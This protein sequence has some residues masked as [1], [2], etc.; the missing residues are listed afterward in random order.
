MSP[1]A[2]VNVTGT[3]T[4]SGGQVGGV[5]VS[6]DGGT[7]W[8]PATGRASWSYSFRAGASGSLT[9]RS[10]AVD[11]TANRETPSAGVTVTI[12]SGNQS[13]PC[14]IWGTAATPARAAETSDTGPL[15]VG[16]KFRSSA[17]GRIT[18]VRF[19]KGATN[20]GTHV[21][22]L[23]TGTGTLLATA[24]FTNETATGWQEVAFSS[25]VTITAGTT[26]V[27]SYYA[28]R[29]NYAVNED[30]FANGGGVDSPPLR[31][32]SD[33][34]DGGN[35]VYGY[36]ALGTFP[37]GTYRSENYWVDVL[38]EPSGADTTA[39]TVTGV[40][41]ASGATGV[42]ASANAT[43]TFSEAMSAASI[44]TANF[45]LRGPGGAL[46]PGAVSYDAASRTATLNPTAA[47]AASTAYTATVKGGASGVKDLA[48]NA[49]ATDRTWTFTT[50]ASGGGGLGCPCSIWGTSA[51]PQRAAETGDTGPLEVGVKFRSQ[52]DGKITALRFYK[53]ATNTG[54]HVGHLWTRT[55]TLLASA[56]F[57]NETA[58]GWQEVSFSSPVAITAGTTYVASYY[59]PRGNYAV[60][61]DYFAG[62]AVDNPPLRALSDG[63]DGGNGVYGYGALGTF[64]NGTYRSEQY[65]VDVVFENDGPDT[66]P[67][68]VTGVLPARDATGVNPAVNVSATFNEPMTAGSI[69]ASTVTLR[70]GGGNPVAANVTYDAAT[71]TA[72]LDP[73]AALAEATTYTATVKGGA[74]GVKDSAGNA[75]ASDD[76]WSFSTASP[77]GPPPDEGPGGPVLVL[78][79]S[80]APFSR[81]YAEI[82][83][84]E[85]LNEFTVKDIS[86]VTAATLGAYD[87]VIVGD[88]ALTAAQVT[89][90]SDWVNG[91][92]DL[93]AM[94]P[95]KQL[96]GLLGLT[97][98]GATLG[99]A[100][101]RIDTSQSPGAGLVGE[102]IQFHGTADR[103]ALERRDQRG[104]ALLERLRG[105]HRA[106]R[107]DARRRRERRV[108]LGVHVR[109]R[110]L[111][112]LHAPGQ[113]GLERAG[114]RRPGAD[115]LGRPVLRRRAGRLG[116]PQQDRDPAGRRAA[117]PAGE[118]DRPRDRRQEAA[119]ALLVPAARAQGRG[120]HDRRRP[121]GR[122]HRRALRRLQGREPGRLLR[123][124]LGV[125]PV[126]LLHLHQHGAQQRRRRGLPRRRIRGRHPRQHE[127]RRLDAGLARG[128]LHEPADRLDGEVHEPAGLGLDADPL[129]RLERL[130]ERRQGPARARDPARRQ[131]LLLAAG[132]GERRARVLHRLGHADALRR[133]RRD[134]DRRLPVGDA[135]DR[136]VRADVPVHD[137]HAARPRARARRATTASSTPTCTPTRWPTRP[138]TRSSP[139]PRPA[140]CPSCPAARC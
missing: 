92:G 15:E 77:P 43:A 52:I 41:P 116:R 23:W 34:E 109:P 60:D 81:Y 3:A 5:E 4:D 112:R 37:N 129:H 33:G 39:P 96:A 101:L 59:A 16:V 49:L 55:G 140:A 38:Y 73:T 94:R 122:R 87:V 11:D 21:G 19:Y 30:Y 22:H 62:R 48:G 17:A 84:T 56:T 76:N 121:R 51:V 106:G 70:D 114:A 99:N 93:V 68:R 139:R 88:F 69:T 8:H 13:C 111:D 118:P 97:D 53:G 138:P 71:R 82:L 32:L 80:T 123:G 1:G 28:P 20:T 115:P 98:A 105:H 29:G 24:T 134:D 42:A 133:S 67:P 47:L 102:T 65:W 135:D 35:G 124:Q 95:D 89:M 83:R 10:R 12:G 113:P 2:T 72:T 137:Q 18:G 54:T 63:E 91:G 9:I 14:S 132:V 74:S 86:T 125:H 26:Y 110:P 44:T 127:L 61:E 120:G 25:P 75:L 57:T 131:L 128:L 64:P 6:I 104:D 27:A 136:R 45:E 78:S 58:T 103:Y 85:G 90:L 117:A 36:G 50:A 46:V 130:G 126:E 100:Y 108:R 31:A 66:S 79:R 107:D 40:A 7:T 119:A